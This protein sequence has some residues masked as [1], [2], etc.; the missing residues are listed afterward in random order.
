MKQNKRFYWI[1]GGL[2]LIG[3]IVRLIVSAQLI[4][5]DPFVWSADSKTDMATYH[6]LSDMICNGKFPDVFYYQPYYYSVFL[7]LAK[8]L[9]GGLKIWGP[10]LAQTLCGAGIIYFA[11]LTAALLKGRIAGLAAAFLAAFSLVITVYTP[12]ALLEV[13]QCFNLTL[14]AYLTVRLM[15]KDSLWFYAGAGLVLS[16][17]ILSRGNAWCFLPSLAAAFYFARKRFSL[18]AKKLLLRLA[19]FAL[20]LLLPQLPFVIRNTVNLGH[21]C[22]PSSAGPAVLTIGNN[23]EAQPGGLN[24]RYPEGFHLWM[25]EEKTYPVPKRILD[26]AVTSPGSFLEFQ[27]RKFLLFWDAREIPNN[28][29]IA[30]SQKMSS[31]L[32]KVPLIPTGFILVL[33]ITSFFL[34]LHRSF[35]QPALLVFFSMPLLYALAT[36]AFYILA[37]FRLPSVG[38]F[39][40]Q[41][42]LCIPL[43]LASWRK[44]DIRQLVIYRAAPA[45]FACMIVYQAYPAYSSYYEPGMMR[46]LRPDGVR[47]DWMT[48]RTV[49]F[50]HGPDLPDPWQIIPLKPGTMLEK[51]LIV[52]DELKGKPGILELH[53]VTQCAN[54]G[55]LRLNGKY[56]MNYQLAGPK[57]GEYVAFWTLAF[58]MDA[59]PA[60]GVFR[61]AVEEGVAVPGQE[62]GLFVDLRRDYGRTFFNGESFPGEAVIRLVKLP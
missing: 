49:V 40:V 6:A 26:W 3:A 39:C 42:G 1:L 62:L 44:R 17:A 13:Q 12:Y 32:D 48:G 56:A 35:R 28:I 52:P 60:D 20:C 11:G 14:L 4:Q 8:L 30:I 36:A 31:F 33:A 38:L 25:E 58:Q 15:K 16:I 50:D 41:A 59:I 37:R 2:T 19:V 27:A 22:G 5:N 54:Q 29:S 51:R 9:T 53:C 34:L 46:M 43:F 21:F 61:I 47:L 23:P 55:R 57:P 10:A 24:P 18:P 45:F 7:P